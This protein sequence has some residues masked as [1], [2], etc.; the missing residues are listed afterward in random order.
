MT[1]RPLGRLRVG[2]ALWL[3]PL[4]VAGCAH[5]LRA[6]VWPGG[7]VMG[8]PVVLACLGHVGPKWFDFDFTA[9]G[10][11]LTKPPI[12][13]TYEIVEPSGGVVS[14]GDTISQPPESAFTPDARIR[15]AI[16]R[17]LDDGTEVLG[18]GYQVRVRLEGACTKGGT[19]A[20]DGVCELRVQDG[21]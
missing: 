15:F 21:R 18:R 7:C 9:H 6:E 11:C 14:R 12:D 5:V 1:G 2:L 19:T 4:S 8:A 20:G 17:A 13:L 16:P 10:G 3:V